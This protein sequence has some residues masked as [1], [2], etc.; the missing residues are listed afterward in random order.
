MDWKNIRKMPSIKT[1][2]SQNNIDVIYKGIS[3]MVGIYDSLSD[4]Q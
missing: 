1:D 2:S 4:K 3:L